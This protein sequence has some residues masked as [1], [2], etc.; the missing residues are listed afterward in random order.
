[1]F[2]N[3]RRVSSSQKAPHARLDEIVRRHRD[4]PY[5]REASSAGRRA[6]DGIVRAIDGRPWMLD[7][8]CGTGASTLRIARENP[9][10]IVIGIDKSAA[11]LGTWRADEPA[12]MLLSHCDLIDF[13]QLA[14]AAKLVCAQQFVLYPNPW[15][16]PDHF[17]R[18]WHGHPV[19]A[20]MMACGEAIE[21]RTN[22][23]IYADEFAAALRI[24]DVE[25]AV[26]EV[27][28]SDPVS[29]FEKKYHASHHVLHRVTAE[30]T[31][32]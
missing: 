19:F 25:S 12:N 9:G 14:A 1:M 20:S 28:A 11:R 5:L 2:A 13:W 21:L 17:K 22:W 31:A 23:R 27:D 18:R 32:R 24:F 10:H 29:P 8:G 7:A 26:S 4:A 15:P 6:F 3:S 30:T 16:K